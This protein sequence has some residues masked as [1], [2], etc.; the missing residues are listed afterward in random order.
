MTLDAKVKSAATVLTHM[1]LKNRFAR[2]VVFAG[3]GSQNSN[4][5]FNSA[6]DCGACG[7]HSGDVNARFFADLLNDP[8]VRIGLKSHSIEIPSTTHF[9][10]A[11]HETVTDQLYL[12]DLARASG[13][14]EEELHLLSSAIVKAGEEQ[15]IGLRYGP[16]GHLLGTR[17]LSLPQDVLQKM[18][19]LQDA[20]F[21]MITIG[22]K[23]EI[24][25]HLN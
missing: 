17:P 4:N 15:E 10:A 2:L 11:V 24:S 7:G 21:C 16:S 9:L 23:I 19:T 22:G 8:A 14:H 3:H 5:A 12:L 1:G 25:R 18:E 6:S 20:H 13:L